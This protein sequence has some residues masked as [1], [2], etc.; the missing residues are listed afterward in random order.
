MPHPTALPRLLA[1]C[2]LLLG[3]SLAH[4]QYSWIGENGVR[5]FS[6]RAPPPS[7]PPHK[8]LKTPGRMSYTAPAAEAS[9]AAQAASKPAPT[10][11]EREL[12]YKERMKKR[13]EQERKDAREAER[14]R[15]IAQR[16][17]WARN[18]RAQVESGIRIGNVDPQGERRFASD[19]ERA[20][21]LAQANKILAECR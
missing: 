16:C 10:V 12:E 13:E 21:Q 20:A 19:E 17:A 9:P 5:H 11:A 8:I 7:T 15:E 1:A 4:A 18:A 3:S 2:A 6:D 14:Q